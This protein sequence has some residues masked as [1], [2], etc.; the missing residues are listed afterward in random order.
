MSARA[1][2]AVVFVL[3]GVGL[4]WAAND[5]SAAVGRARARQFVTELPAAP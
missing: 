4:F 2:W 1:E 3:V 5:Y